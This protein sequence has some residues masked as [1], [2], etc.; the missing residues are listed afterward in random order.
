MS[1]AIAFGVAG[2]VIGPAVYFLFV[3][4]IVKE[5][6]EVNSQLSLISAQLDDLKDHVENLGSLEELPLQISRVATNLGFLEET[7]NLKPED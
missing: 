5:L 6:S 2:A 7:I 1:S 4:P 3:H